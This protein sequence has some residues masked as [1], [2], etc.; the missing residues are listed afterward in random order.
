MNIREMWLKIEMWIWILG[1]IGLIL[2]VV[3]IIFDIRSGV[4]VAAWQLLIG[5]ALLDL[6]LRFGFFYVIPLIF[7]RKQR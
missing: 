6:T 1:A 2:A 7:G 3:T 4:L 5:P